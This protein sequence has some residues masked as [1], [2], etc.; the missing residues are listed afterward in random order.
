MSTKRLS[1]AAALLGAAVGA[2]LPFPDV[3]RDPS[4]APRQAEHGH[5]PAPLASMFALPDTEQALATSAA[6]VASAGTTLPEIPAAPW[7]P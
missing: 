5:E 3:Q 7:S 1:Y 6:S 2:F 4:P